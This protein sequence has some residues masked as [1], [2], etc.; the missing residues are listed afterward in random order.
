M[1][2]MIKM[3]VPVALFCTGSVALAGKQDFS[4]TNA[5]GYTIS[6]VYV[7]PSSSGDWEEDVMGRD[8]L[9]DGET[10]KIT[11]SAKEKTCQYDIKVVWDDGDEAFWNGFDLCTVSRVTLYWD[12]GRAWADYE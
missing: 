4:L 11:F 6:E 9:D 12:N 10:V 7:S 8:I 2:T 1:N 5:T 3:A